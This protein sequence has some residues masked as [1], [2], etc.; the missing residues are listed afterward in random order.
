MNTSKATDPESGADWHS[1]ERH[2]Q[3]R[4]KRLRLG[5][6]PVE[7]QLARYQRVTWMLTAMPLAVGLMFVAL[8]A[9]FGRPDVGA[10]VAGVLFVPVIAIAWLDYAWL[11]S[12]VG[13][14]RR[15]REQYQA[16]QAS[17]DAEN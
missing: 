2:W 8:F 10:I 4:L 9:A 14:Y 13:R 3:R 16:K 7:Q 17:E 5:A 11:A 1:R 15:E 6:E 12:K